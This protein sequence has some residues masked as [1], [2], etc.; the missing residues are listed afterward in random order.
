MLLDAAGCNQMFTI[1]VHEI[2]NIANIINKH[3]T[4][5]HTSQSTRIVTYMVC[6]VFDFLVF[7]GL[8]SPCVS[9]CPNLDRPLSFPR[10]VLL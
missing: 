8:G 1:G 9:L 10:L 6:F 7:Y 5:L 3:G 2:C 4:L